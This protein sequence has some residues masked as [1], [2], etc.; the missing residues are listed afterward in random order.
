MYLSLGCVRSYY[1]ITM[2][3][4]PL[5]THLTVQ[6]NVE[7]G[8]EFAGKTENSLSSQTD[9]DSDLTAGHIKAFKSRLLT[10]WPG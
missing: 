9:V 3:A 7:T 2:N 6:R 8:Q 1:Y 10:T 5:M 4:G